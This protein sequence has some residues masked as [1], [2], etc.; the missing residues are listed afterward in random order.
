MKK[1]GIS[2]RD[3]KN[4]INFDGRLRRDLGKWGAENLDIRL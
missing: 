2:K 1:E 3:T 4:T